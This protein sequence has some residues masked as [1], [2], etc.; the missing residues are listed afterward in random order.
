MKGVLRPLVD[1]ALLCQMGKMLP[2]WQLKFPDFGERNQ[3]DAVRTPQ[4]LD[5]GR[6]ERNKRTPPLGVPKERSG[7][8]RT[9]IR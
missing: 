2:F 1:S 4:G 6:T 5:L 9:L 3:F 8:C 7:C